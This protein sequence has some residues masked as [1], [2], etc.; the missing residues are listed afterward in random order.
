MG[1]V[2]RGVTKRTFDACSM[3]WVSPIESDPYQ[4]WHSSQAENGSNYVGFVNE[5]ADR[6]IEARLEF[7][8]DRRAA[9]TGN[10][11]RSFTRSSRTRS[12]QFEAQGGGIQPLP[13]CEA[14]YAG[15]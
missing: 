5:E 15:L 9:L 6:L 8:A 7:D 10:S 14:V 4:I 11:T 2:P 13:E 12:I 1:D 3:A